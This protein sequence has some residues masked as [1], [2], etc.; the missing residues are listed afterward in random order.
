[1]IY[2]MGAAMP[3]WLLVYGAFW[4]LSAAYGKEA[5]DSDAGRVLTGMVVIASSLIFMS[6]YAVVIWLQSCNQYGI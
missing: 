4:G 1:M 5:R 3:T 2:A 6:V